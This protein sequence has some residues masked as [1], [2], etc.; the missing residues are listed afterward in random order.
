M[1]SCLMV[2]CGDS[3]NEYHSTYFYPQESGGKVV[4]A[5][6]PVDSTRVV[7]TD[8][9]TLTNASDWFSVSGNGQTDNLSVS[10]PTGFVQSTP[11]IFTIQ[12]NTTGKTRTGILTAVSSCGD[13][14]AVS[15]SL[16]QLPYLKILSP[17]V[18]EDEGGNYVFNL[19]LTA[20]GK[21][22]TQIAPSII[23]TIYDSSATLASSDT[24]LVPEKTEGFEAGKQE[25][26]NLTVEANHTGASRT[27][28][29]TLTSQG[30]STLV[31]V[32][33]GF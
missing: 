15:Q 27:A 4:Y 19:S 32:T 24:W 1:A 31:T 5:D 9:W 28:T 3:K 26:I 22:T 21:T 17:G 2:S 13:I 25:T 29:L 30:V 18:S 23:F 10:V 8:A 16:V 7:S 11:L 6:Q 33:Q 14:G 20:E 12:P